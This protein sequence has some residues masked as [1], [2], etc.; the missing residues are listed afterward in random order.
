MIEENLR[1]G[2]DNVFLSEGDL[3]DFQGLALV[4]RY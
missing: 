2:G 3:D 1:F 4:T